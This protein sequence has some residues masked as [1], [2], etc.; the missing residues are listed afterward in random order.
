M[1]VLQ[2]RQ[3]AYCPYSRFQVGAALLT[4]DGSIVIGCN[5]ENDS[6]GLTICAER[7]AM[8]SAVADGH[9]EFD[10]L[11]VA[12]SGGLAPCGACRQVLAQ[13]CNDLPIFLVDADADDG[14]SETSLRK[15]FPEEFR[16]P[17]QP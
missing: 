11:A 2:V 4:R 6:F 10:A 3:R 9:R 14:V 7:A 8:A 17:R 12:S 13:F 16:F 1:A 15:L 5:V